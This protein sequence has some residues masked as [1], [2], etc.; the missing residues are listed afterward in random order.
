MSKLIEVQT[1]QQVALVWL[2]RPDLRNAL[3]PELIQELTDCFEELSQAKDIRAVVLAG[4]G[5]AFCAGADLNW[6]RAAASYGRADNEAGGRAL[7]NMLHTIDSCNKPVIARVHGPAFAGGMGLV[8]ACDIAI[9]STQASFALTEVKLGL[10]ASTISPYV[11]RSIGFRAAQKLFL[12]GEIIDASEAYRLGLVQELVSEDDLDAAVNTALGHLLTAGPEAI[13]ESK[14]LIR[15]V[16]DQ[17]LAEALREYTAQHIASVRAG[18]EAQAG[19]AAFFA[20]SKAP[21]IPSEGS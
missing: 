7:A 17:P 14:R 2:N 6:M 9:A 12:T 11:L 3:S 16:H 19:L 8:A 5:K 20:K 21:W 4:R 13:A 1:T 18:A 10:T 15:T